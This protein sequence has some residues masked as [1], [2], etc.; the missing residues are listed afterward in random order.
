MTLV[1]VVQQSCSQVKCGRHLLYSH[2]LL[3][4]LVYSDGHSSCLADR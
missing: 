3:H 2:F 1:A 4:R